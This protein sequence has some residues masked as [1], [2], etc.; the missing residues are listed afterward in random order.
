[1]VKFGVMGK[2]PNDTSSSREGRRRGRWLRFA[3]L[4]AAVLTVPLGW[5]AASLFGVRSTP[6]EGT[7]LESTVPAARSEVIARGKVEPIDGERA[8]AID[9]VGVLRRL[10]VQEGDWVEA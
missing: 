10:Y 8:L 2:P 6:G 1:M 5:N 7:S 4:A 3:A 9:A